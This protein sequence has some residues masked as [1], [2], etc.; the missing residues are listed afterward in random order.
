MAEP[1]FV[2]IGAT[3]RHARLQLG[4]SQEMFAEKAILSV[5]T[6]RAAELGHRIYAKNLKALLD[7]INKARASSHSSGGPLELEFPMVKA[8]STATVPPGCAPPSAAL[9]ETPP[10]PAPYPES[11]PAEFAVNEA[12]PDTDDPIPV[13]SYVKKDDPPSFYLSDDRG[14]FA[15]GN[16]IWRVKDACEGVIVFGATGSGKTSGSGQLLAREYLRSGFGGLV[17]C[18]KPDEPILWAE[19]ASK[20]GRASDLALFGRDPKESFNFLTHESRRQG[21][22]A[23]LTE[24]LVNVFTEIASIGIG[25]TAGGGADPFWERAMKSLVR[26]CIDLLTAAGVPITLHDM[27]E[28]VRS[29]PT[30]VDLIQSEQWRQGSSCWRHVQTAKK[31]VTGVGPKVDLHEV[32]AYWLE[33][34]PTLGDRTRSS[35]VAMFI[36]L[37]EALMRSKMRELFCSGTTVAPEDILA[38]KIVVVD[39]PVKEWGEVGRIAAVLWKYCFQK[40]VERRKDNADG[41]GRPVFLWADECQYFI[42]R[43]DALFQATARSSRASTVYLTQ[44]IPSLVAAVGAEQEGRAL[45]DSLLNNLVTKI[46]H[47]N[48]DATT[49]EYAS[50][51]I[52][53]EV[54]RFGTVSR[55]M[56]SSPNSW[57]PTLTR[58]SGYSEQLDDIIHPTEFSKLKRGGAE[59]GYRVGA[60]VLQMGRTFGPN[61]QS[62]WFVNFNQRPDATVQSEPP[63]LTQGPSRRLQDL[64]PLRRLLF[65]WRHYKGHVGAQRWTASVLI[66]ASIITFTSLLIMIA[67]GA[68]WRANG[69]VEHAMAPAS[70]VEGERGK[71][72]ITNGDTLRASASATNVK[73]AVPPPI[74][75]EVKFLNDEFGPGGKA[76]FTSSSPG[77]LSVTVHVISHPSG[78]VRDFHFRL[79]NVMSEAI[80]G[81]PG[82]ELLD[83]GDVIEVIA[84]GFLPLK[85]MYHRSTTH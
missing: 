15:S 70:K 63:V 13:P 72:V 37:A 42:S 75:V 57:L 23:N 3:L 84:P 47:A 30:S 7:A 68:P 29:A 62:W 59:N 21:A 66:W 8:S 82:R 20:M 6:V 18:A 81:G 78:R 51:L 64:G 53:K 55:S 48:S 17:L 60:V 41:H 34:F 74:P 61:R 40:T 12:P 16:D 14:L 49:N 52:G 19:Y 39:L 36:T 28:V 44:S 54:K 27:F 33:H 80:A 35:I 67:Y 10:D 4:W 24:N 11:A 46:F 73:S 22:G 76:V 85:A 38:G 45:V 25:T 79:S 9:A 58:S 2:Q 77:I 32:T 69:V 56:G 50:K 65:P 31:S 71:E 26:N 1:D 83:D 43:H 5:G